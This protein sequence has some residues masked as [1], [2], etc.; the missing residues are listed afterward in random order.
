VS[1]SPDDRI[2]R[3]GGIP[4]SWKLLGTTAIVGAVAATIAIIGLKRIQALNERLTQTVD[5]L[6]TNVN[7]AS[8]LR[9]DLVTVT[10]AER[11]LILARSDDEM[12]RIEGV[13]D[14]VVAT[15]EDRLTRL[16]EIVN[17]EDR[18]RLDSFAAKWNEWLQNHRD[19]RQFASMNSEMLAQTISTTE[20]RTA[21]DRLEIAA[22]RLATDLQ[23]ELD[24]ARDEDAEDRV[25]ELAAD[26]ELTSQILPLTLE[27]QRAEKNM[28]VAPSREDLLRYDGAL[29]EIRRE[30]ETLV[31]RLGD[32][33]GDVDSDLVVSVQSAAREYLEANQRIRS[34]TNEQGDLLAYQFVYEIGAPLAEESEDVLSTII[35]TNEQAMEENRRES[36][37]TYVAARNTLLAV[38]ILGVSLSVAVSFYTGHSIAKRLR[39]L[40]LHAHAIEDTANLSR[41][42]PHLGND[43]VGQLAESFERMRASLYDH[44][45]NLQD[46]TVQ[47]AEMTSTLAERNVEM[48]QFVYTVSHDLK[49]PLVSC[50]GLLG[51][52]KEDIRGGDMEAVKDSVSRMDNAVEQLNQII[53]DLLM[54][55]RIGRKSLDLSEIDVTA[56]VEHAFKQAHDSF[57]ELN[58]DLHI[59]RELPALIADESDVRRV[60]ENLIT[61]ALK[62]GS[63]G[64]SA[65]IEVGGDSAENERRYFVRDHGPGID[66]RYHQ[67][68]FGL[69]QRLDT[70]QEGTGVGLAS[71]AKIMGIHG[72]RVWVESE[73]GSGATFWVAFPRQDELARK[74]Q[75]SPKKRKKGDGRTAT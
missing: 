47:L 42:T 9:Q 10:R 26:L 8:L 3:T 31:N 53:D 7:Q 54:L 41:P 36:E 4:L 37:E 62:Y 68:V 74:M 28:I 23:N 65:K 29:A 44:T 51:L 32:I 35:E 30:L 25:G 60:F 73:P 11:N 13:I 17:E 1:E 57:E 40:A 49:S 27:A 12:Q 55:S 24:D 46:Q 5:Y 58:V 34:I 75:T 6:A 14:E 43:E 66:P 48:E 18:Q 45:V 69:F 22:S 59:E 2:L 70:K 71:V 64:Q 56:L 16:R 67:K 19:V 21:V 72:G 15:M 33:S 52:M 50:K 63:N 38:S 39:K 61:N 20:A